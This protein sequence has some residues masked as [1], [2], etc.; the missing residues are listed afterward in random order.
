MCIHHEELLNPYDLFLM[1]KEHFNCAILGWLHWRRI[2]ISRSVLLASV[3][4]RKTSFI[5]FIATLLMKREKIWLTL[6]LFFYP[7]QDTQFHMH[8]FLVLFSRYILHLYHWG[9]LE[10]KSHHGSYTNY[11]KKT[12]NQTSEYIPKGYLW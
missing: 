1:T 8:P 12:K 7:Q 10:H 5:R 9:Y 6:F 2:V 3:R 11:Q 4:V